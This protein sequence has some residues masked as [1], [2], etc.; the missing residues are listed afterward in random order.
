MDISYL[1]CQALR[2]L[3]AMGTERYI[4]KPN[5]ACRPFDM[6]RDGFIYGEACG[7]VVIERENSARNR[8]I[9]PYGAISVAVATGPYTFD[10]LSK[11]NADYLLKNLSLALDLVEE[12]RGLRG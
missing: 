4:D 3:G 10:E 12:F 2:T 1:E 7:V 9:K 8:K 6:N 11:T 5:K